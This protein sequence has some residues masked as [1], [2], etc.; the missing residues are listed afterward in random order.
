M[1][2]VKNLRRHLAHDA[3]AGTLFW[4]LRMTKARSAIRGT[5]CTVLGVVLDGKAEFEAVG[6]VFGGCSLLSTDEK[7]RLR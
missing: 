2:G 7:S 5:V 6:A 1:A 4:Y 3:I